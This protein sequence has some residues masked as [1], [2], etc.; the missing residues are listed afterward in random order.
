MQQSGAAEVRILIENLYKFKGFE[1]EKV[2]PEF[3]DKGWNVKC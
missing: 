3:Y 1:A 2:I